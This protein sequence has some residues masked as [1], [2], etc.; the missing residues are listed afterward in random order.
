[1]QLVRSMPGFMIRGENSCSHSQVSAVRFS[2]FKVRE[3]V[4]DG[5]VRV[6]VSYN[7]KFHEKFL[8]GLLSGIPLSFYFTIAG[9]WRQAI[10]FF[11]C[12]R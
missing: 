4:S 6:S 9:L 11:L 8:S 1:M 10:D 7:Y 5:I 2:F 3:A 12:I